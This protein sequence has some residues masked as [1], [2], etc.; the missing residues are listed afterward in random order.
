[1]RHKELGPGTQYFLLAVKPP[2]YL[3]PVLTGSMFLKVSL[4]RHSVI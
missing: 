1:M 3:V 4:T 2:G